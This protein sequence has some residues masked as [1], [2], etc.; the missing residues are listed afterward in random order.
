M[1]DPIYICKNKRSGKYSIYLEDTEDG[2]GL[3]VTPE[4]R[5]IPSEDKHYDDEIEL[6]IDK[7]KDSK[8]VSDEQLV[9]FFLYNKNRQEDREAYVKRLM[10]KLT[11]YQKEKLLEEILREDELKSI[12]K[13]KDN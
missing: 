2:L 3:Y 7:N 9:K 6:D 12:R 13:K 5:I 11:P 10:A 4:S 1:D 8:L